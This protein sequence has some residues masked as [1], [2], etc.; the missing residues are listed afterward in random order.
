MPFVDEVSLAFGCIDPHICAVKRDLPKGHKGLES[1]GPRV[2]DAD[3]RFRGCRHRGPELELTGSRLQSTPF[4]LR[5]RP[6]FA[7][8]L[9]DHTRIGVE[10][11]VLFPGIL[12]VVRVS[13]FVIIVPMRTEKYTV[14]RW[15]IRYGANRSKL[16][17]F[18]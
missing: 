6:H 15:N 3:D 10:Q 16:A 1:E 7:S 12:G 11:R 13:V 8:R 2:V 18:Y 17:H 4:L 5:E 14:D 9:D